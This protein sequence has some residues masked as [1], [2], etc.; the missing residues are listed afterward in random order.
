MI[1]V[2]KTI[3]SLLLWQNKQECL[4]FQPSLIFIGMVTGFQSQ[5]WPK[6]TCTGQAH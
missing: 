2:F 3:S 4:D 5:S 1:H 6:I